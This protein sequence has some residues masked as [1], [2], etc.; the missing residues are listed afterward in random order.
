MG[1]W[2]NGHVAG[3]LMFGPRDSLIR[4]LKGEDVPIEEMVL[5][6]SPF[7]DARR[8]YFCDFPELWIDNVHDH[9]GG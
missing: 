5:D 7:V 8:L 2:L 3:P 9:V 4:I 1:E 6:H